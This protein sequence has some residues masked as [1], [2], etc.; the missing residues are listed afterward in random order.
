MILKILKIF[1]DQFFP[2]FL[3]NIIIFLNS[4][5]KWKT[6]PKKI[7]ATKSIYGKVQTKT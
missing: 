3:T 4:Q 5:K 7:N 1:V 2:F 6:S